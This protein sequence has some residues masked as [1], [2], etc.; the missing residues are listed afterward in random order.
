M[1][2]LRVGSYLSILKKRT[3][4]SSS[5]KLKLQH[6]LRSRF[7]IYL[8]ISGQPAS[9]NSWSVMRKIDDSIIISYFPTLMIYWRTVRTLNLES[10]HISDIQ[11]FYKQDKNIHNKEEMQQPKY[12]SSQNQDTSV[13]FCNL[14]SEVKMWKW[15]L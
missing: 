9:S 11:Y 12:C 5:N 7:C 14:I 13:V 8:L 6:P 3:P 1:L 10:S 15:M 2:R 4:W